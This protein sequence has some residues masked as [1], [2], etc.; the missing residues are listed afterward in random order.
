[1]Y[2]AMALRGGRDTVRDPLMRRTQV[3]CHRA[4]RG[5]IFASLN[6]QP[7]VPARKTTL[8]PK[9]PLKPHSREHLR[10]RLFYSQEELELMK[11]AARYNSVE[12][13]RGVNKRRTEDRPA[14][15]KPR[16]GSE[17][18]SKKTRARFE[19]SNIRV[20][21]CKRQ[22][23]QEVFASRLV[24][25]MSPQQLPRETTKNNK[26]N[27]TYQKRL[28]AASPPLP[29]TPELDLGQSMASAPAVQEQ[30]K[31]NVQVGGHMQGTPVGYGPCPCIDCMNWKATHDYETKVS[32]AEV[33]SP[34]G[35][36]ADPASMAGMSTSTQLAEP[37]DMDWDVDVGLV[38]PQPQ[39]Q[40]Q[41]WPSQSQTL[42]VS[43]HG[44][45]SGPTYMPAPTSTVLAPTS[46]QLFQTPSVSVKSTSSGGQGVNVG[47]MGSKF[48]VAPQVPATSPSASTAI[49]TGYAGQQFQQTEP[50]T[51]DSPVPA[52]AGAEL[53]VSSG[54]NQA[55]TF[56]PAMFGKF[57]TLSVS[58]ENGASV[59][60]ASDSPLSINT[61]ESSQHSSEPATPSTDITTPDAE[62][63]IPPEPQ[64]SPVDMGNQ[65]NIAPNPAM[66]VTNNGER[67][68]E[69]M[70]SSMSVNQNDNDAHVQA[71]QP[72]APQS[73]SVDKE[74]TN[75]APPQLGVSGEHDISSLGESLNSLSVNNGHDGQD[76]VA[77]NGPDAPNVSNGQNV[78]N[79][80]SQAAEH[81][82]GEDMEKLHDKLWSVPPVVR[83]L[84]EDIQAAVEDS[85]RFVLS[86]CEVEEG[87]EG[88]DEEDTYN[89]DENIG[90][91][92]VVEDFEKPLDDPL[93]KFGESI[94]QL[95]KQ[96][97]TPFWKLDNLQGTDE[98]EDEAT[99]AFLKH[100]QKA[101]AGSKE[102][103]LKKAFIMKCF[104]AGV[105]PRTLI[106]DQ[107]LR[108]DLLGYD[109]WVVNNLKLDNAYYGIVDMTAT[110]GLQGGDIDNVAAVFK[111][112]NSF[113]N[114]Q[115]ARAI[116]EDWRKLEDPNTLER[117]LHSMLRH[118]GLCK[119]GTHKALN[120]F[121]PYENLAKVVAEH[122]PSAPSAQV[123]Q[124][125]TTIENLLKHRFPRSMRYGFEAHDHPHG[126]R[127]RPPPK[128]TSNSPATR[129]LDENYNE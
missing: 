77:S 71:S 122:A 55:A 114:I 78:Q 76:A 36:C 46:A 14:V 20:E 18:A 90:D 104:D 88:E 125:A 67:S 100:A 27:R 13:D 62:A 63:P 42:E 21:A 58:N 19:A 98:N 12:H 96:N 56:E 95:I 115:G 86:A 83:Y 128:Q 70:L 15:E 113:G 34:L 65:D 64:Q 121:A 11:Q 94:D 108:D 109:D 38:T 91:Y 33:S 48:A 9:K 73:P 87:E 7:K 85:L 120:D 17:Q 75:I 41:G 45:T 97:K 49:S 74:A 16:P 61:P 23:M 117:T 52:W 93:D 99:E 60:A 3:A 5:S 89:L 51:N 102:A 105:M 37:V 119:S 8:P 25:P 35:G 110:T 103:S 59:T 32:A 68:L 10:R 84:H 106:A 127:P 82:D 80:T 40:A 101:F 69:D 116:F 28:A 124:I 24:T 72:N 29:F 57:Q 118:A 6:A 50:D 123:S 126:V 1:M 4:W 107:A 66:P 22:Y 79:T 43:F 44:T 129:K 2:S 53:N 81:H 26:Q 39:Q 92:E 47:L 30:V 112:W 54:T 31:Y 111:G